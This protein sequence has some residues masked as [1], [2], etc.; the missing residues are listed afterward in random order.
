[1]DSKLTPAQK[2]AFTALRKA[3]KRCDDAGILLTNQN[4]NSIISY[5]YKRFAP[6]AVVQASFSPLQLCA[7]GHIPQPP[8]PLS[9]PLIRLLSQTT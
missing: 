6:K 5:S 3:F 1:M 8:H 7:H 9:F 4:I 2:R